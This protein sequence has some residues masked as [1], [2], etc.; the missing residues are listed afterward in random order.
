M[1][2][3]LGNLFNIMWL[4]HALYII[5]LGI[6]W[7]GYVKLELCIHLAHLLIYDVY[8]MKWMN[9][10]NTLKGNTYVTENLFNTIYDAQFKECLDVIF[11]G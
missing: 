8:S 5:P 3:N 2:E 11:F 7:L 9:R 10:K 1:G 4:T 6:V